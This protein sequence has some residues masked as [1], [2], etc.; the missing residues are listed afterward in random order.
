MGA[1]QDRWASGSVVGTS[2]SFVDLVGDEPIEA[3]ALQQLRDS[4]PLAATL[5][6]DGAAKANLRLQLR[7]GDN[8]AMQSVL[9][10]TEDQLEAMGLPEGVRADWGGETYLNLVWQ[11]E[12]VSGMLLG[13]AVTLV[14]V[15]ILLMALFRSVRWA[16]LA[17]APVLG[18][19]IVVF[20]VIGLIGKDYDMPIAV[21]STLVLGIG[22][23]FAI[24]FVERYRELRPTVPSTADAIAEF[25]EEP[26]RAL[27]RN[28][29]V[30]AIG[31]M[32][33]LFSSLTPYVV[34][35]VFLASIIVLSWLATT[36]ALPALVSFGRD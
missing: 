1:L 4:S 22:V 15:F 31:F 30:V 5:I 25:A 27:T 3:G 34:V 16:A 9:S 35:G 6:A 24:H 8:Q 29:A 32:P 14:I 17:I 7:N 26:A 18:T 11:D 10:D 20:G 21:L 13:F 33:L 23:D 36:V 28:A 12:M 19:I 2:A